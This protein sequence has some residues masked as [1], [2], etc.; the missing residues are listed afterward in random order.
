MIIVYIVCFDYDSEQLNNFWFTLTFAKKLMTAD[1]HILK[2]NFDGQKKKPQMVKW[3]P[4]KRTLCNA[5]YEMYGN[6]L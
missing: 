4:F 6:V 5:P 3:P 2:P 1:I